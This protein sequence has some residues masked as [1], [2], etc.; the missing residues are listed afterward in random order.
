MSN[1]KLGHNTDASV[2]GGAERELCSTIHYFWLPDQPQSFWWSVGRP[3]DME[4][5]GMLRCALKLRKMDVDGSFTAGAHPED[6]AR[7]NPEPLSW[8]RNKQT[9][10]KCFH[11]IIFKQGQLI[12]L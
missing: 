2:V 1:S 9:R 12:I 6:W 7:G 10:S 4:G 11:L 8:K 3:V 5:I